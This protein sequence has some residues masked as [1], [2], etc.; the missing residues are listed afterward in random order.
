[1]GINY[2]H[3]AYFEEFALVPSPLIVPHHVS[4]TVLATINL[5]SDWMA[6]ASGGVKSMSGTWTDSSA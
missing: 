1:M 2:W 4:G 6:A 3:V 5:P